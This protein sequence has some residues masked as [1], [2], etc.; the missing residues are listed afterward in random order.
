MSAPAPVVT[1]K[2]RQLWTACTEGDLDLVIQ[3]SSDA[4]VD[5]NWAD[6]A[7][8]RTSLYRACGHG[9]AAAAEILLKHPHILVNKSQKDEATPF[10][11]ACEQGHEEV[12]RLLMADP[13]VDV[14]LHRFPFSTPFFQTCDQGHLAVI[15]LLLADPRVRIHDG[16]YN[17]CSPLWIVAHCG[18]L[19]VAQRLLA[20]NHAW[21]IKAKTHD[22]P[23]P[24]N[25][26]SALEIANYEAIA[27]AKGDDETDERFLR[28]TSNCPI[29][30]TWL[31][32]YEANPAATR[33]RLRMLPDLS[34]PFIAE[35]FALVV[36]ICDELLTIKTSVLSSDTQ[37]ARFFLIATQLP[38]ELQMAL[39]NRLFESRKDIV[40]TKH[41][42]PAF[43]NLARLL[44]N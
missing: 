4:S 5:V 36:F 18:H 44:E 38:M 28:R 15:E 34:G 6:S 16:N 9:H 2:E 19:Q 39:C 17:G 23:S 11:I 7:E 42:E 13:R 26:K 43:K 25:N 35:V 37:T 22:G 10:L 1:S 32:A 21:D 41:S 27:P 24:W 31:E 12:V 3:L 29:I 30:A 20:S 14:N 40:L 8:R 33:Q